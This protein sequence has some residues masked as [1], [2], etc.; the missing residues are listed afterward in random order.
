MKVQ[1][2]LDLDKDTVNKLLRYAVAC[3]YNRMSTREGWSKEDKENAIRLALR[4]LVQQ[5]I[6][7]GE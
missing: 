4:K 6:K 2:E 5:C 1:I 3:G 7:E